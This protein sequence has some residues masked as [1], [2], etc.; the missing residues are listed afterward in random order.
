MPLFRGEPLELAVAPAALEAV[1][2]SRRMVEDH[3]SQGDVIYGLTTGFGKLKNVAIARRGP[4][5]ACSEN[6]IL[7]HCCGIGEAAGGR[8]RGAH[9]AGAAPQRARARPLRRARRGDRGASSRHVNEGLRAGRAAAGL[10]RRQ[11]RPG[12]AGAHGRRPLLGPRRGRTCARATPGRASARARRWRRLGE[13]PLALAAK[14]GLALINGTEIMKAVGVGVWSCAPPT[15]R[16]PRTPS[17]SLSIEALQGSVKPF[18]ARLAELKGHAGHARTRR[19]NVRACLANSRG[20][21][22][23]TRDCDRVQDPYSLRCVPQ[24]HGAFK[25]ALAHVT[26]IVLAAELNAV[27]DNPVLFPETGE[28]DQRRPVPR[29]ADLGRARLPGA[30]A[31][32]ASPTC[33]S[34]ASSSSSTPTSRTCRPS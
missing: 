11:R 4:R 9:G 17:P 31:V 7:S 27:T 3:V 24:I 30:G 19:S 8:M 5:P 16:A 6:L 10:G 32:H 29:P 33:R 23:A 14:E 1:G 13:E 26:Q 28:S 25:T 12:A 18:D 21:R 34:A 2:R 15:S 20:A 22:R